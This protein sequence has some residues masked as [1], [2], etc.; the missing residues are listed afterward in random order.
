LN[1][2]VST[3]ANANKTS[4]QQDNST[5]LADNPQKDIDI[6]AFQR[7]LM[8]HRTKITAE[9]DVAKTIILDNNNVTLEDDPD[10]DEEPDIDEDDNMEETDASA[11]LEGKNYI[12][13]Y[14]ITINNSILFY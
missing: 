6:S 4:S 1:K 2:D 13:K 14:I 3:L 11:D 10:N 9:K 12:F 7:S 5:P 8:E